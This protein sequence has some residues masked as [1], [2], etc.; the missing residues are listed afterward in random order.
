MDFKGHSYDDD[1]M[2]N[3]LMEIHKLVFKIRN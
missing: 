2:G 3:I 1:A